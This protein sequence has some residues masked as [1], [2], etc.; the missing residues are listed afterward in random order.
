MQRKYK[1]GIGG[2]FLLLGVCGDLEKLPVEAG[3]G[4]LPVLPHP[5]K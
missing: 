2:L 3:Y 4:P 5:A 1:L